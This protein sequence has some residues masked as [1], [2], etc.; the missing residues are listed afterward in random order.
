ML[1]I[2]LGQPLFQ[3][4]KIVVCS[5]VP[6]LVVCELIGNVTLSP[7]IVC[8]L[9]PNATNTMPLLSVVSAVFTS[10]FISSSLMH[11]ELTHLLA[12]ITCPKPNNRRQFFSPPI[13]GLCLACRI[14]FC[15]CSKYCAK[16]SVSLIL[17]DFNILHLVICN[18]NNLLD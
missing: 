2:I 17:L 4:V 1:K 7:A 3:I 6:Q 8:P 5:T 11:T 9:P 15:V 13:F 10:E 18:I 16:V 14:L 12:M